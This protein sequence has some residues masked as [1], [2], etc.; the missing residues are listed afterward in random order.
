MSDT[1]SNQNSLKEGE[2]LSSLLF[3]FALV[4]AIRKVQENEGL[5]L[6]GTHSFGC[7]SM[8]LIYWIGT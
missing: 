7:M 1:F 4:H 6:N 3:N 2:T 5:E 8:T